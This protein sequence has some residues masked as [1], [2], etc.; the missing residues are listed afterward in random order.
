[1]F[2]F[3]LKLA[4]LIVFGLI[5]W[6]AISLC[7]R[8]RG[9]SDAK[10]ILWWSGCLLSIAILGMPG[11]YAL[12][13][14]LM[15]PVV[16]ILYD[17]IIDGL[18]LSA[19]YHGFA[20][21][22][23]VTKKDKSH[24]RSAKRHLMLAWAILLV[25][26]AS[27]RLGLPL[28]FFYG[29]YALRIAAIV[30]YVGKIIYWFHR[31]SKEAD[32]YRTKRQMILLKYACLVSILYPFSILPQSDIMDPRP[33]IIIA[34]LAGILFYLGFA[35]PGWFE[36]VLIRFE[37]N[38]RL[39]E[40]NLWLVGLISE[41]YNKITPVSPAWFEQTLKGFCKFLSLSKSQID[42]IV[43]ASYLRNVGELYSSEEDEQLLLKFDD[44]MVSI[45]FYRSRN[46]LLS[47]HIAGEI[48][49][50][51]KI[52]EILQHI[53]ERWDG[54]G[55][56]DKLKGEEIPLESRILAIVDFFV[57]SSNENGDNDARR[58]RLPTGACDRTRGADSTALILLTKEAEKKFDPNLVEKFYAFWMQK[59]KTG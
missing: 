2:N 24:T 10:H 46:V 14:S 18:F 26:H 25:F 35:M 8:E 38:P 17:A 45:D 54:L 58:G 7:L 20:F 30:Y 32:T 9:T 13:R 36:R 11:E 6:K 15:L 19:I 12:K 59:K 28:F 57:R 43:K 3:F 40:Q 55:Y 4:C 39:L 37:L 47:A 31:A 41:Y 56:P 16:H 22:T 1:M 53:R 49:H 27:Y 42:L 48:L 23:E 50:F 51:S 33:N 52:S 5:L 29:Y 21:T 44:E 34:L